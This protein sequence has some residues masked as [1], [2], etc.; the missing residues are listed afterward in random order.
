LAS[1]TVLDSIKETGVISGDIYKMLGDP[2]SSFEPHSN[3]IADTDTV[4]VLNS[5]IFSI[6]RRLSKKHKNV[7]KTI[8]TTIYRLASAVKKS[9][10]P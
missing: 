10:N 2:K 7:F 9:W 6:L 3:I 5:S 1:H 8:D 4:D